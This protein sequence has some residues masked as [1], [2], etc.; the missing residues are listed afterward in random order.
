MGLSA[1][2]IAPCKTEKLGKSLKSASTTR[3]T[4][5]HPPQSAGVSKLTSK[6]FGLALNS[7]GSV[8]DKI[9]PE[10]L[11]KLKK[12]KKLRK[13]LEDVQDLRAKLDKGLKTLEKN[14]LEKILKRAVFEVEIADLEAELGVE[15]WLL[16][17]DIPLWYVSFLT[18]H[19]PIQR[20]VTMD[21][22][23][24]LC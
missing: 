18:V 10:T 22:L 12:L 8:C 6:I 3:K 20:E 4:K 24:T 17:Y 13:K 5:Q 15:D 16:F 2:Y 9:S 21:M 23:E 14:Q 1:E 19:V 11:E 7:S